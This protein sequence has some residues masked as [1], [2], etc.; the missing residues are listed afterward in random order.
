MAARS[1]GTRSEGNWGPGRASARAAGPASAGVALH[2]SI[3]MLDE[4]IV[5]RKRITL[6]RQH[7]ERG[8]HVANGRPIDDAEAIVIETTETHFLYPAQPQ[9]AHPAQRAEQGV[10]FH[11]VASGCFLN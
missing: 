3:E 4:Q 1:E 7:I 11:P 5:G 2:D 6:R 8:R 9:I 10:G